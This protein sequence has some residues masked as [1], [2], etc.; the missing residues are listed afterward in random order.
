MARP[1]K[2][3]A[4]SKA[5]L[6]EDVGV[7]NNQSSEDNFLIEE[8]LC[9]ASTWHANYTETCDEESMVVLHVSEPSTT[10]DSDDEHDLCSTAQAY[11]FRR[12]VQAR[13]PCGQKFVAIK[14]VPTK[15]SS[16]RHKLVRHFQ[17]LRRVSQR[18]AFLCHHHEV[19]SVGSKS[20]TAKSKDV[21]VRMEYCDRGTLQDLL[22]AHDETSVPL[23]VL[24]DVC[25]SLVAALAELH[26]QGLTHGNVRP[27]VVLFNV[28]GQCKLA[29]FRGPGTTSDNLRPSH[30]PPPEAQLGGRWNDKSDIWAL[31]ALARMLHSKVPRDGEEWDHVEP[32]FR[33]FI[34]KCLRRSPQ[35]RSSA[36]QLSTHAFV[37]DRIALLKRKNGCSTHIQMHFIRLTEVLEDSESPKA[38]SSPSNGSVVDD[39]DESISRDV[40]TAALHDAYQLDQRAFAPV[41]EEQRQEEAVTTPV[42][43]PE[44][45]TFTPRGSIMC[46]TCG[47]RLAYTS[48]ARRMG[49]VCG[50]CFE[51]HGP[52]L[53]AEEGA[54]DVFGALLDRVSNEPASPMNGTGLLP[55]PPAWDAAP[56]YGNEPP[57]SYYE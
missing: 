35:Q 21:W 27:S 39:E 6:P 4:E 26:S 38:F 48:I 51:A 9:T 37:A 41:P 17:H 55:P 50:H 23:A 44:T 3:G 40:L 53:H 10:S 20:I 32:V 16:Q 22:E 1:T 11:D 36:A 52:T 14:I 25:A 18:S 19:S 34:R 5:A 15:N 49:Y 13:S 30:P 46:S 42:C 29:G 33:S 31:G 45:R 8:Q 56:D 43:R 7:E 57:P 47:T 2:S 24:G 12:V 28:K 54:G